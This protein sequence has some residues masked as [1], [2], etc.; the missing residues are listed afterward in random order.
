M[1]RIVGNVL[2]IDSAGL[3]ITS[4]S[5]NNGDNLS[6]N[7]QS[8]NTIITGSGQIVLTVESD[9]INGIFFRQIKD[10]ILADTLPPVTFPLGFEIDEKI[11][12]RTCN[13]ATAWFYIA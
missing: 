6:F 4:N 7:F 10:G 12:V 1:N 13:A 5:A 2:I 9:T 11:F 3:W 8:V